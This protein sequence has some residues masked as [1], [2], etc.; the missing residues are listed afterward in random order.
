MAVQMSDKLFLDYLHCK[1]KAYLKLAGKSG[2]KGDY[3]KFLDDQDASYRRC[4][5]EHFQQS[6]QIIPLPE[7]ITTF[8]DVKK[9]KPAVATDVSIVNDRYDLI[10]D[11]VELKSQALAQKPIYHPIIY[12]PHQKISKQDKLL[13]AFCGS[14]LSHE[15]KAETTSGSFILGD[16]LS[17]SK[18][19]LSSL[20]KVAGKI[21][22]EIA[23]MMDTK[24]APPL[25]LN[26]HCKICEFQESC[27]VA[28]KEKDDLSLLKGLSGKEIDALNKRG[29]FT[30]T[31]YSYTFRPRRS[32]KLLAQKIVKHQHS[33]N[34]LAIRT[35]T[36]YIAGKIELPSGPIRVYLDVEGLTDENF[37]YLIGF[38]IDDG[39]KVTSH[40]LWANDK[41]EETT[42]WKAFLEI[43]ESIPDFLMFHY[44]SYETKFI[45][46]MGSQYGGDSELL[47]KIRL[48]S[49]NVLSAIYGRIYFPTYSND[50]KSVAS[51]LGFKWSEPNASGLTSVLW[52]KRWGKS[53]DEAW[54]QKIIAYNNDDCVALRVVDAGLRSISAND[55]AAHIAY[56][57]KHT[58]ELKAE[59]P[60][61]IFKR[62]QF[63]Y[64]ELEQINKR[65][66]FDY[67]RSKVFLRTS[68][69]VKKAITKNKRMKQ[70]SYKINKEISFDVPKR[71]PLCNKPSPIKHAKQSRIVYD[72]KIFKY[73]IKRW[74]IKYKSPRC[75]CNKCNRTFYPPAYQKILSSK[76]KY[77]HNLLALIIYR[78]IG[79]L[80][81]Q[82]AIVEDL[83]ETFNYWFSG[84]IVAPMKTIAARKYQNTSDK[85][86][87]K[88]ISGNLIHIDETKIN[89]KGTNN[90]VW[91]ITNME[92][93]VYLYNATR[94]S[95]MIKEKLRDFKGVLVSDFYTAYDSIACPQQKCLIH[96]I[97]DMNEDIL[98]NPF[99][100][101]MKE[102]GKDFTL[103]LSPIVETIDKYGLK[104]HHLNKHKIRL[105]VF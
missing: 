79:R 99:D 88:I 77:G 45:K 96:L 37:Y 80:M 105:M 24:A 42:S 51:F 15:Q 67:Q 93:V 72:L 73:G 76:S 54:K 85:L 39:I 34:A 97:R 1:Y 7:A 18:V 20:I 86:L 9:Q 3:E 78:N 55:N 81:S 14:A 33:L 103:I 56:P 48:R 10:L 11:A 65:A 43:I 102:I 4:A 23:K 41:S 22:K 66:Y 6:K 28:A 95:D 8:K 98:K 25:R 91:A 12:L 29:I 44:G 59:K 52:R 47:E 27:I 63:Y 58:D 17:T 84:N 64:P 83:G 74:V 90:Y 71:C 36:I 16:K 92:N 68:S 50:L 21:E 94:E 2:I 26:A 89:A 75:L 82:N 70:V 31:Q 19:Q 53:T 87:L 101:E 46:Q 30:V 62:N 60:L 40:S 49:F 69:E 5:W 13:L 57:V 35:Q 100:E 38:L 61:G 32:K 104:R